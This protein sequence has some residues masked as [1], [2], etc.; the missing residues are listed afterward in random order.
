M[1]IIKP[2]I[3]NTNAIDFNF[4]GALL[5][6]LTII[7]VIISFLKQNLENLKSKTENHFFKML[8][9]H[10]ENVKNLTVKHIKNNYNEIVV[11]RRAFVIFRLQLIKLLEI[12]ET[13][14]IELELNLIKKEI[15]DIAY[16]AF[17]YGIDKD[18]KDFLINK[19]KQYKK[20]EEIVDLLIKNKDELMNKSGTNIGRTNQTSL[21]VY[22]RN[23]Y[24][25]IKFI[26]K[27]LF[28]SKNEKE[29]FIKILRAQL[30]NPELYVIYLNVVS[31]F[32]KKWIKNNF[33]ENYEF[34]K[35]IPF[36]YCEVYPPKDFFQM[37]YEEEE[38]S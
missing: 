27:D 33:I 9:Y 1:L 11:G 38:I 34:F 16:I 15:I 12:V 30:S 5:T 28:L 36:D 25:S 22:F 17:Y 3:L 31:R 14:N 35:N 8:D 7:L 26:D 13:I 37:E 19:L 4:I 32:G 10:S 18:W 2:E 24:N 29:K 21:S 23:M 20:T 6:S